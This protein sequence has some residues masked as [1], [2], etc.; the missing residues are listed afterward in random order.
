MHSV[1][2]VQGSSP[3]GVRIQVTG[4][5]G[6]G[7]TT[8]ADLLA[9]ALEADFVDLDALNWQ[10]GWR[11]LNDSDPA[12]LERRFL[13]ATGGERW[14]ASGSY[15][16]HCQRT[17]WPR[18]ETIVWLDL[19]LRICVWRII[20]RT[21][22]RWRAHEL[23]WGTNYERLWPNL[24]VW[25]K[26]QPAVLVRDPTLPQTAWH[27]RLPDRSPLVPHPLRTAHLPPRGDNIPHR[28]LRTRGTGPTAA[29]ACVK[30][31]ATRDTILVLD[32]MGVC[33]RLRLATPPRR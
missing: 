3:I 17:F 32:A 13:A 24:M 33:S 14:V 20:R 25:R 22:R 18:L 5:S 23:L 31:S 8:V 1:G 30:R 19:P 11:A 2:G 15:T 26:G 21:W 28:R 10:P 7:K 4:N 9:K 6:S 29:G 27:A 12:E 16:R